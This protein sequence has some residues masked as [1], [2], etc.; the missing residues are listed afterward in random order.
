MTVVVVGA[1]VVGLQAACR[2]A[3]HDDVVVVDR[4]PCIGGMAGFEDSRAIELADQACDSGVSLRLGVTACRWEANRVL[5]VGHDGI[6]WL[7]ASHLF[8]ASGFRPSTAAELSIDGVRSAGIFPVTVAKHL[9]ETG[10]VRW[11]HPI[12]FSDSWWGPEIAHHLELAG[13]P[14]GA[15]LPGEA[16]APSWARESWPAWTVATVCGEPRVESVILTRSADDGAD[17]LDVECDALILAAQP[18]PIRNIEGAISADA[19]GVTYLND[20]VSESGLALH[21]IGSGVGHN[22]RGAS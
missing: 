16:A 3:V 12:V 10:A 14:F 15:V 17:E 4:I 11:N 5:L 13:C 1:G 6:A 19:A 21:P 22:D 18:R 9:L 20:R 7:T 8:V 2:L